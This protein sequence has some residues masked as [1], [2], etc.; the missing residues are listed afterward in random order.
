MSELATI[1]FKTVRDGAKKAW[2]NDL[3]WRK[4]TNEERFSI[5][6]M[7]MG[8]IRTDTGKSDFDGLL[9]EV[10]EAIPQGEFAS[11]TVKAKLEYVVLAANYRAIVAGNPAGQSDLAVV[12]NKIETV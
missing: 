8:Y 10:K 12:Q 1:N 9:A 7:Y 11:L 3:Q 4:A 2:G 5:I 6:N